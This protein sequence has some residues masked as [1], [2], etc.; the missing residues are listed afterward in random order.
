MTPR[1][2][3]IDV[4]GLPRPQGSMRV[5]PNGG[6]QYPAA[7]WDWRHQVQQAAAT[8]IDT[9]GGGP[10]LGPV[11]VRLGFDMPHLL[12]HYGTGRNAGQLKT[13]A[14]VYPKTAPDLDKLIRAVNDALTDAGVWRDD[15]QV[16][17]LHAAKRYASQPGVMIVVTELEDT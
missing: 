16:A 4:R 1:Q 7:V 12:A 2:L 5:F 17:L 8:A 10:I 11:E 15:G 13:R 14:P 3:R 9:E 6:T